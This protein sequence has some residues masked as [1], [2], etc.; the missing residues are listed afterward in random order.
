MTVDNTQENTPNRGLNA[1]SIAIL[2]GLVIFIAMVGVQL[3]Q[4]NAPINLGIDNPAPDFAVTTFDGETMDIE[5]LAGNVVVINFWASWCA[6]CHEEADVLQ[7]IWETYDD[8]NFIMMGIT[9]ADVERDSREFIEQ[10]SITYPNAPD[11]GAH[12]YDR[13]GL[14]AVPETFVIAPDGTLAYVLRGPLTQTTTP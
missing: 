4:R 9:H 8:R 13:Y 14:T 11:P 7:A 3:S 5:S 2:V 10:Y 6:P 1:A 12:I